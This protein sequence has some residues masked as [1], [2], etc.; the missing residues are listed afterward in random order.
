MNTFTKTLIA[1]AMAVAVAGTASANPKFVGGYSGDKTKLKIS[2]SGCP[3]AKATNQTSVVG[4]APGIAEWNDGVDRFSLDVAFAGCWRLTGAEGIL[5]PEIFDSLRGTYIERKVGKDLTMALTETSLYGLE[6][7]DIGLDKLET[8][9]VGAMNA[10]LI[11]ESKCD[12]SIFSLVAPWKG[13]DP[14]TVEVKKGQTKISKNGEKVK[15]DIQVD[16][17]YNND[18]GKNKKIKAKIS[19]KMDYD[20]TL[21]LLGTPIIGSCDAIVDV[22]DCT[23]LHDVCIQPVGN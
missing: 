23:E 13:V 22:I 8:G 10:H 12:V 5:E 16:A 7:D 17:K 18:S 4:F 9:I 2:S 14:T 20:A 11:S 6:F 21:A 3:N 19:G 1:S 15:V